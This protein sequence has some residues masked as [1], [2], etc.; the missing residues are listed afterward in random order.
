[1]TFSKLTWEAVAEILDRGRLLLLSNLFVLLLVC[2]RLQALPRQPTT[3]EVH[4]HVTQ[5]LKVV[6]S[7]LFATKMGIDT[8]V[9]G[10]SLR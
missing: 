1:M 7:G 3:Q 8:H 9:S 4:E 5:S 6:S 2:R 10:R